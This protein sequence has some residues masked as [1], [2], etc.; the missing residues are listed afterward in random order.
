MPTYRL[1]RE[2]SDSWKG[3][4]QADHFSWALCKR[5]FDLWFDVPGSCDQIWVIVS[6]MGNSGAYRAERADEDHIGIFYKDSRCLVWVD[7]A[8]ATCVKKYS[9]R[10][11]Y[12]YISVEYEEPVQ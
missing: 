3:W 12:A 8:F 11:G 4:R 5:E 2:E 10:R 6:G 1:C 9:N 7:P